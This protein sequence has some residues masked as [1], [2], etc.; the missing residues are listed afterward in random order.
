MTDSSM[1]KVI[2]KYS[3]TTEITDILFNHILHFLD[4][5]KFYRVLDLGVD[6]KGTNHYKK[7]R[8]YYDRWLENSKEEKKKTENEEIL[9][10]VNG[11]LHCLDK[12]ARI[13]EDNNWF[14]LEGKARTSKYGYYFENKTHV[15]YEIIK[16]CYISAFIQKNPYKVSYINVFSGNVNIY[17]ND[18]KKYYQRGIENK[19]NVFG[20]KYN[21]GYKYHRENGPAYIEFNEDRTVKLKKYYLNGEKYKN[22]FTYIFF[23]YFSIR[24]PELFQSIKS[25]ITKSYVFSRLSTLLGI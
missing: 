21:F 12:P 7:Q 25:S 1:T 16:P 14:F 11:K 3:N 13:Y 23:L 2:Q 22:A 19:K 6:I 5:T 17:K 10:Y 20:Y 15:G 4:I 9:T 8:F 24:I 18:S